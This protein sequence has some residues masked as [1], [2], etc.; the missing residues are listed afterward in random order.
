M[1]H[2]AG[3]NLSAVLILLVAIAAVAAGRIHGEESASVG[4][5]T[6]F[7]C[8]E[9]QSSNFKG[10][11]FGLIHDQACKRVCLAENSNNISGECSVFMC[12]CSTK[13]TS[14]TVAAASAPIPA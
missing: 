12:W 13:C 11:C 7:P 8:N 2:S 14:E 10:V 6:F 3:K 4:G 1:A 9:Y 5:F